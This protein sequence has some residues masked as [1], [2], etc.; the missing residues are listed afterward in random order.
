MRHPGQSGAA[1]ASDAADRGLRRPRACQH[2]H[3]HRGL[4]SRSPR[5]TKARRRSRASSR[6][7]SLQAILML[8]RQINEG[9]SEVENQYIRA[10][11]D[12]GNAQGAGASRRNF[13]T[14]R[15][16]RMARARLAARQRAEIARGL[17][18]DYRRR[19]ALRPAQKRRPRT[20]R[21][22][23]AARSCAASRSRASASCSARSARPTRRW[24]PA[25]SRP[26]APAPR[27]G[28]TAVSAKARSRATGASREPAKPIRRKLDLK[29]GRVDLSHG[30]GGRAMGQSDRGYLPSP[31]STTTGCAPAT[32]SRLSTSPPGA[33]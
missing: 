21:P 29:H 27:I 24:A 5:I 8:V 2:D 3:R 4:T 28:P 18:R 20:I 33:W 14:A 1:S 23:N 19:A 16:V 17:S 25:W 31:P 7:T 30:A 9:R 32:T 13:R 22:A 6:S 12:D 26:R 11:T 15:H 10:V